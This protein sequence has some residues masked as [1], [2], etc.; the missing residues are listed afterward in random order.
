MEITTRKAQKTASIRTRTSMEGLTEAFGSG[1]SEIMAL[2]GPQGVQ[3]A[4]APFA[5]YYNMDMK[6]LDVEM[7][8]PVTASFKAGG[9]VKSGTLP[10]GWS[11]AF[12][13]IQ[14]RGW[15]GT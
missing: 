6:D 11:G 3:P 4:G 1:Y 5:I 8:F 14:R 10:G 15:S 2:L 9:R 7:G 12:T 13:P